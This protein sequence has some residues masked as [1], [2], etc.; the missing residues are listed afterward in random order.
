MPESR[1]RIKMQEK[2]THWLNKISSLASGGVPKLGSESS[3]TFEKLKWADGIVGFTDIHVGDTI[4]WKSDNKTLYDLVAAI[5]KNR[6]IST[7]S[8]E[9]FRLGIPIK[10]SCPH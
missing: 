8:G 5:Q 9:T 6:A 10:I 4:A 2:K 3:V 7:Q 1:R